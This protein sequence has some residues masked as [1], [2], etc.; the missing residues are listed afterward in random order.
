MLS[1]DTKPGQSY[2]IP[3]EV[4]KDIS[5]HSHKQWDVC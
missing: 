2:T 3:T 5:D 4:C 1:A